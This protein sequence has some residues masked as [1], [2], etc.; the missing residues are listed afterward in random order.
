MM[1]LLSFPKSLFQ[2]RREIWLSGLFPSY[3]KNNAVQCLRAYKWMR[4]ST[5]SYCDICQLKNANVATFGG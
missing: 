3:S 1:Q 4:V 2:M 5:L